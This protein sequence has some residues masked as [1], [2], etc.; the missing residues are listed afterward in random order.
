MAAFE[1]ESHAVV[2]I[3]PHRMPAALQGVESHSGHVHLARVSGRIER[4]K[5]QVQAL[6]V[7]GLHL[8]ALARLEQLRETLVPETP[9]HCDKC[10]LIGYK[11]ATYPVTVDWMQ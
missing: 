2:L 5:N 1:S 6:Q 10:N 4:G 3:H 11:S 9:Y 7:L 8:A